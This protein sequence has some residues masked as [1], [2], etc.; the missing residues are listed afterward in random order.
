M[1]EKIKFNLN[2]V[3]AEILE[4]KVDLDELIDK[5]QNEDAVL[6]LC[7][8]YD[9]LD[10]PIQLKKVIERTEEFWIAEHPNLP[11]CITHGNTKEEALTNLEDAKKGWIYAKLSGGEGIPESTIEQDFR[12]ASGK[13]LLRLPKELHYRISKLARANSISINQEL[14]YLMSLGLGEA[15]VSQSVIGKLDDIKD[16]LQQNI[17]AK[18]N[19][20]IGREYSK[21][22]GEL[23]QKLLSEVKTT[24]TEYYSD[25]DPLVFE[26]PKKIF[27][28]QNPNQFN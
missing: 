13:I 3:N 22:F 27:N 9:E 14:I 25:D 15:S 7:K 10:Y 12:D 18:K 20:D 8:K 26:Q 21:Y 5:T 1:I 16:L 2:R 11:G 4:S 24:N 19:L 17:G 6:E 23:A 28:R